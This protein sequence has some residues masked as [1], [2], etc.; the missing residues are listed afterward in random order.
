MMI[1][2][3]DFVPT[4]LVHLPIHGLLENNYLHYQERIR[5]HGR[6]PLTK[7]F[8]ALSRTVELQLKET[9]RSSIIEHIIPIL[10]DFFICP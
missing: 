2:E 3:A 6:L 5:K 10:L 7:A 4:P 8:L 1:L 9:Q